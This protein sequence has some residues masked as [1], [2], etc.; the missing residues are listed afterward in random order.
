[1]REGEENMNVPMGLSLMV[2]AVFMTHCFQGRREAGQLGSWG[3]AKAS[4]AGGDIGGIV[5]IGW[6]TLYIK[7]YFWVK[8]G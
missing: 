1:M 2:L 8:K 6:L 5:L 3:K 7:F 4:S